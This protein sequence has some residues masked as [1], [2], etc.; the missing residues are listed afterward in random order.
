MD[1]N[2]IKELAQQMVVEKIAEKLTLK[3]TLHPR[4]I[5]NAAGNIDTF[6]YEKIYDVPLKNANWRGDL[7]VGIITRDALPQVENLLARNEVVRRDGNW[8]CQNWVLS[9][10]RRLQSA[11]FLGGETFTF[12]GLTAALLQAENDLMGN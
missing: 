3:Q 7:P 2:T 11:G 4:N 12:Q 5:Y 1:S 8:N 10:L 9:G 6:F